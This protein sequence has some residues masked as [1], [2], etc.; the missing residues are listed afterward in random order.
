M[1][2]SSSAL[3]YE[4]ESQTSSWYAMVEVNAMIDERG[5][6]KMRLKAKL[7][8]WDEVEKGCTTYTKA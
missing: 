8:G 7:V 4:S 2:R 5:R 6:E 1:L 3:W